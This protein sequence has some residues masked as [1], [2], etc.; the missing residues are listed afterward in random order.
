M[1]FSVHKH[2]AA[3][4]CML[5]LVGCA[6]L[7]QIYLHDPEL[8]E[9][10]ALAEQSFDS[11]NTQDLWQT[12]SANAERSRSAERAALA[13]SAEQRFEGKLTN[14]EN[15]T[16]QDLQLC[17]RGSCWTVEAAAD[18]GVELATLDFGILSDQPTE[19]KIAVLKSSIEQLT[20]N[21]QALRTKVSEHV[22][23]SET[24]DLVVTSSV[25]DA[26]SRVENEIK[27]LDDK[28][29]EVK[30]TK[31]DQIQ[32]GIDK[33]LEPVL[34]PFPDQRADI[35][36]AVRN[37][38][39][40]IR[41]D[42]DQVKSLRTLPQEA[43]DKLIEAAEDAFPDDFDEQ[44]GFD[45]DDKEF[46]ELKKYILDKIK[47][48]LLGELNQTFELG[49]ANS[50]IAAVLREL[51]TV[52]DIAEVKLGNIEKLTAV[53]LG[54][55]TQLSNRI[56]AINDL[57]RKSEHL[58]LVKLTTVEEMLG[59]GIVNELE[60]L[61]NRLDL[62][63]K[64]KELKDREV[65]AEFAKAFSDTAGSSACP[66]PCKIQDILSYLATDESRLQAIRTTLRDDFRRATV[67]LYNHELRTLQR[68]LALMREMVAVVQQQHK[69]QQSFGTRFDNHLKEY[70]E[71]DFDLRTTVYHDLD[72][73]VRTASNNYGQGC[74]ANT[75]EARDE[76]QNAFT[77]L[78][79]YFSMQGELREQE[80]ALWLDVARMEHRR[81][82][83]ASQIA[84]T[85][86]EQFIASGLQG[87]SAFTQG[88]ITTEQIA[89][90]LRLLN[91]GLL[92][93]IAG[94]Q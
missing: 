37:A 87:L 20:I 34:D 2:I 81:S 1:E 30:R 40:S 5:V 51:D 15:L 70:K 35:E 88:G 78:S 18:F 28:L 56:S 82:I 46:R 47:S 14:I 90:V 39:G 13:K 60:M 68:E 53:A 72:C 33:F 50:G 86:H 57:L 17:G 24:A 67:T 10:A 26:I 21:I 7:D 61:G 71:D 83:E 23:V 76:I 42:L 31:L 73:L 43:A 55:P 92:T 93:V 9:A 22:P 19:E 63:D 8:A 85:A 77:L 4:I 32:T 41:N 59:G 3:L 89:S 38:L 25:S 74:A 62:G 69:L 44:D 16:W 65:S 84:A 27:K 91:T 11:A 58:D 49:I 52:V 54:G 66:S 64:F 36:A 48:G 79:G 94:E 75:K 6:G 80:I 45:E 29:D 12:M